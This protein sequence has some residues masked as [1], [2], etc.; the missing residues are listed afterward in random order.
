M[1]DNVAVVKNDAEPTPAPEGDAR[2]FVDQM[3]NYIR[4]HDMTVRLPKMLGGST[5][6]ISPR[7]LDNDELTLSLRSGDGVVEG[8]GKVKIIYANNR[9]PLLYVI[10]MFQ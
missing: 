3:E 5:L 1:S 8:K 9:Q 10:A 2:G 7:N 4:T 6:A